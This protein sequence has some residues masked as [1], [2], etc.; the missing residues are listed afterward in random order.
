MGGWLLIYSYGNSVYNRKELT[1]LLTAKD[2]IRGL[3]L[4]PIK[5]K[6]F[7]EMAEKWEKGF[8]TTLYLSHY[9]LAH[10]TDP[11]EESEFS[12]EGFGGDPKLWKEFLSIPEISRYQNSNIAD[13]TEVGARKAMKSLLKKGLDN[14]SGA[15]AALKEVMNASKLLQQATKRKQ[16][17]VLTYI[18]PKQ[19]PSPQEN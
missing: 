2:I 7:M 9:E 13:E 16:T 15:V 17:V 5:K 11:M 8:P 1:E 12:H 6:V 4:E 18:S 19:Y 3:D 14:N 10:G